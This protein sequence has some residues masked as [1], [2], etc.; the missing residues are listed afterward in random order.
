MQRLQYAEG[1]PSA[2]GVRH[3]PAGAAARAA[4]RASLLG[5]APPLLRSGQVHQAV[6]R[7]GS[8]SGSG[9][10]DLA[11]RTTASR[12]LGSGTTVWN[13]PAAVVAIS[14]TSS[15]ST[16]ILKGKRR[17]GWGVLTLV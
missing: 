13:L 17:A 15:S 11:G 9:R 10:N 6:L 4:F 12:T 14:R 8:A 16:S 3:A 7:R 1:E 2:R 5:R